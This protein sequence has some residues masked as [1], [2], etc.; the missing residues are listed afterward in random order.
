MTYCRHE[1]VEFL[2][3]LV[4]RDVFARHS[5]HSN[6][7]MFGSRTVAFDIDHHLLEWLEIEH[8]LEGVFPFGCQ[9]GLGM[10]CGDN[11]QVSS[12][13]RFDFLIK[14]ISAW[15]VVSPLCIG[16]MAVALPMIVR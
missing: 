13:G 8:L 6:V 11:G 9:D 10:A 7:R 1:L 3:N 16:Q 4:G 5:S 2:H 12:K 15:S 14:M